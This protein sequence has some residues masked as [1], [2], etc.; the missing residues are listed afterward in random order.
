MNRHGLLYKFVVPL[1]T[2]VAGAVLIAG[3]IQAYFSYRENT[4]AL[5]TLQHE[6]AQSA[7]LR[8]EQFVTEVEHQLE[9]IAQT[10]WGARG[11]PIE[12]RRLDSLRLL[13][14]VPAVTEITH[15][16]P[17]GKER[18]R[19]SR[20][21]MD[22]LTER[23]DASAARLLKEARGR[24]VYFGPV[25][26]RKESEPYMTIALAGRGEEGGVIVA[27]TNLKFIWDVVAALKVGKTGYAYV[28]DAGGRLIAHP[29]ISLVLQ[30]TEFRTLPQVASVL[31]A[32][33]EAGSQ[34]GPAEVGSSTQ[35]N[36]VLSAYA[37][38]ES[39]GW[40]VYV[41]L[42]LD[43]AYEQLLFS[44]L[45]TFGLVVLS[46]AVSALAAVF[47]VRRLVSPIQQLREG[48]ARI[49]R[50]DLT[51]R[52]MVETG[53]E[54]QALA[55]EF[56][57]MSS[58]LRELY[59][60]LEDKVKARTQELTVALEQQTATGDVLRVI[61]SSPTNLQPTLDIV[62]ENSARLCG[63]RDAQLFLVEENGMRERACVGSLDRVGENQLLPLMRETINGR[64]VLDRMVCVVPDTNDATARATYPVAARFWDRFGDQATVAVPLLREGIAIGSICVRHRQRAAI[65]EQHIALLRTFSD[66]A[67]IAIEN[68]RLFREIEQKSIELEIASKHKSQFLANMS[69]E[70]RTPLNAILGYTELI[71]DRIYGEVPVKIEEVLLRVQKSGRHLLGL[72]NDVLDLSKIEAG[73]LTLAMAPFSVADM[74]TS[75][76]SAMESLASEKGLALNVALDPAMNAAT[77]DSRRLTQVLM[78]LV[79]NAVKFTDQGSVE[80]RSRGD[81]AHLEVSVRDTG[82][83]IPADQQEKIFE[84]FQQADGSATK[85]K[86]G[87]GLGLAISKRI[88]EMHGGRLWVE[89]VLGAGSTFS[90]TI[91]LSLRPEPL[92]ASEA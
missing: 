60:G 43:E 10:P 42:P 6:K 44:A 8:I 88:V 39:L 3:A 4:L 81:A 72:I 68:V 54:L 63:A 33:R 86:G 52:I 87:T 30:R 13:R 79:G 70:L 84:E 9:W 25:Y 41:D 73:Q 15:V 46:L 64:A 57:R 83:G 74:V 80:I 69:H 89:S 50:G 90:F 21:A 77:G 31:T 38:I 47:L 26:F 62:V 82:P 19:V 56:N 45:R 22:V 2:L 48:A 20:L 14:H 59:A 24:K 58:E 75:V 36:K 28:V 17:V 91:P 32:A 61:S 65:T 7:A 53:D 16:D 1:V 29:D 27:E 71:T 5:G 37:T 23:Q 51:Q 12:Q 11:V 35:G 34:G 76:K 85:T 18:L 67:V 78:N 55:E 92:R 49:G 40:H 66:Q